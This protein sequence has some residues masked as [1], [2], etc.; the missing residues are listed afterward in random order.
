MY[1]LRRFEDLMTNELILVLAIIVSIGVYAVVVMFLPKKYT[2]KQNAHLKS[3]MQR[4]ES[5]RGYGVQDADNEHK[6]LETNP[7]VR[8]FLS[9]PFISDELVLIEQAGLLEKLDKVVLYSV[10][11]LAIVLVLL[12]SYGLIAL[13]I[14]PIITFAIVYFYLRIRVAKRRKRFLDLF[15]DALD[16]IVRSVKAGYPINTSIGMVADSMPPEIAKEYTRIV[17]EAS[18][19]YTLSEAVQRFADRIGQPDV[20]FFSVVIGV[21]QETGG[22]LSEIL[23]NLSTVIR[24]RKHLRLKIKALSSEGKATVAI[25]V[26]IAIFMVLAVKF[27]A[28]QHFNPLLQTQAGHTVMTVIG[29]IFVCTFFVIRRIIN[30]RI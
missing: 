14:A 29:C 28:P 17:S 16:I 2:Q 13:L 5:M 10:V 24:Q 7:L 21:Q 19:G 4:L 6:N 26:G 22:N 12:S 9:L 8:A 25:L 11:L 20:N 3:A 23:S 1:Q 30:F 18:F 15:P 27:V